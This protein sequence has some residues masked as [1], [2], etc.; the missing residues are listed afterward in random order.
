MSGQPDQRQQATPPDVAG[1]PVGGA[2]DV[3]R[4]DGQT[5]GADAGE[6]PDDPGR[7]GD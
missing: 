3:H 5:A 2:D 4:Q 6:T 1:T 7:G